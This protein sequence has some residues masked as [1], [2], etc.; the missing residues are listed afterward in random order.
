MSVAPVS[1]YFTY[2]DG[3]SFTDNGK[4]YHRFIASIGIYPSITVL[5]QSYFT[6]TVNPIISSFAELEELPG[7]TGCP[8]TSH[9]EV[10]THGYN[11]YVDS[12]SKLR[13]QAA[14]GTW[15]LWEGAANSLTAVATDPQYY[16]LLANQH[17]WFANYSA[18]TTSAVP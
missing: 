17:T 16:Y 3:T 11:T 12:T 15:S 18:W 5:D 1:Y 10:G 13:L 8:S 4:T 6:G 9:Q 14:V 7:G 2:F